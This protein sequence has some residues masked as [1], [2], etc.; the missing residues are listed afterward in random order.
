MGKTKVRQL[1]AHQRHF[2]DKTAPKHKHEYCIECNVELVTPRWTSYYHVMKCV[3]CNSF[4]SIPEEHN[5]IAIMKQPIAGLPV[6][7]LNKSHKL[8]GFD[9]AEVVGF[10]D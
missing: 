8:L 10:Y 7:K 5:N 2:T 3:D 9:G 4:N 6:L 1:L